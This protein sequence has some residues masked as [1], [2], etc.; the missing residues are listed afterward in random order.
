[1]VE[2]QDLIIFFLL[3][4]YGGSG[5]SKPLELYELNK[6]TMNFVR[7]LSYQKKV[8]GLTLIDLNNTSNTF[9]YCLSFLLDSTKC[10]AAKYKNGEMIIES[11]INVFSYELTLPNEHEFKKNYCLLSNHKI[12][13]ICVYSRKL[14]LTIFKYSNNTLTLGDIVQVKLLD[15]DYDYDYYSNK[16]KNFFLINY[17]NKGL[18][19]YHMHEDSNIAAVYK[20]YIEESCSSFEI[21]TNELVETE[22]NFTEYINVGING[23]NKNFMILGFPILRFDLYKNN[24]SILPGNTVYNITDSFH[25]IAFDSETP[26]IIKFK[27]VNSDYE[28]SAIIN[29]FH[30]KIVVK[31]NSY[32]C[33]KRSSRENINNITYHDLN[34][35]FDMNIK[36]EVYFVA[37]FDNEPVKDDLKYKYEN[38]IF[39]CSKYT[40][41]KKRIYCKLPI[42][43]SL[44]PPSAIKYEYNIFSN[45]SCSNSIYIGSI[46]IN[47]PYLIETFEA[48]NLTKISESIDKKYNVSQKIEKFSVDMINYFYWFSSF[49][50]CDDEY[51]NSGKCCEEEILK[52]WEIISHK[53]YTYPINDYFELLGISYDFER[54]KLEILKKLNINE[55]E[56]SLT[57]KTEVSFYNY[58][59]LKSSKYQK[60]VFSFPGASTVLQY[61]S[62][63]ILSELVNYENDTNIKV[64]KYFY[65]IFNYIKNDIFNEKILNEIQSNK[66]YQI[67]FIGHGLG[68]AIATLASY[69]FAKNNLAENEPILITFGQPRV[70][71][72]KF[73]K[74]YMRTVFQVY[75]IENFEDIVSIFPPIKKFEEHDIV[76]KIKLIKS[77]IDLVI[78]SKSAYSHINELNAIMKIPKENYDYEFARRISKNYLDDNWDQIKDKIL[79]FLDKYTIQK[80]INKIPF[81]YCHIGGLYVLNDEKNKFYH[82]KDVFL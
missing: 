5:I 13:L 23:T 75:R 48:N 30:P 6:T 51:I 7:A 81:G 64:N 34:K 17:L 77:I 24:I 60:Y 65:M 10:H 53:G 37:Q 2:T 59:I 27:S 62:L 1:M 47:D 16:I 31:D 19:L 38:V 67:I 74:N 54:D 45:L 28:C 52:D 32:I 40:I 80:L 3:F 44:F 76:I 49:S 22:I 11:S 12:A 63:F 70:G 39:N 56:M 50:Y 66:E 58:A 69:Y 73:A 42:D 35:T 33:K 57:K 72:E 79:G 41:N 71:N 20:S 18:V 25:F 82:C 8:T 36:K 4:K 14:Y 46:F 68:G 26:L 61:F 15:Y 21:I 29:I 78:L 55:E 9:I 43:L